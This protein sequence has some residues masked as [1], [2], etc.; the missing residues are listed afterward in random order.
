MKQL[1]ARFQ[2][3]AVGREGVDAFGRVKGLRGGNIPSASPE[4]GPMGG[5]EGMTVR[6]WC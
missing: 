5:T 1:P 6:L 4:S 3:L 2:G